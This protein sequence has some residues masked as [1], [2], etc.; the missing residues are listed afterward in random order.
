MVTN[1]LQAII[2]ELKR[3]SAMSTIMTA[4]DPS[5]LS[6]SDSLIFPL[7]NGLKLQ[8]EL[9]DQEKNL[10]IA[11]ILGNLEPGSYRHKIFTQALKANGLAHPLYGTLGFSK[12]TGDLLLFHYLDM[13]GLDGAKVADFIGP[14]I[15]KAKIWQEALQSLSI[16]QI[17]P[18]DAAPSKGIFGMRF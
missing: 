3:N 6:S 17:E 4:F 8:I 9:D 18:Q 16:P 14:F 1:A 13:R 2:E 10:L 12:K 7:P 15:E 11:C 5:R